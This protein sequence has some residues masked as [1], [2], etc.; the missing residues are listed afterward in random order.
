M[1]LALTRSALRANYEKLRDDFLN[2]D[3]LIDSMAS[4]AEGD[5]NKAIFKELSLYNANLGRVNFKGQHFEVTI[6]VE[7][8]KSH[9][10]IC[11][12]AL[13]SGELGS[14]LGDLVVAVDHILVDPYDQTKK[15]T[16][17]TCSIIQTK[18]E[19]FA[20]KGLSARQ[21]YLMTQWPK[22]KYKGQYWEFEVF[23]DIFSFY[24][25]VLDPS[26]EQRHKSSLLSSTI[27]AR[28]LGVDKTSLLKRIKGKIPLSNPN[29]LKREKIDNSMMPFSF[30]SF[31]IKSSYLSLGSQ[32]LGVR[33]FLK[34]IFFPSMEEVEDC[35][36]AI[37][38]R[39][40][41][42][43]MRDRDDWFRKYAFLNRKDEDILAIRLKV[44]LRR[45]E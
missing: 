23:P 12:M 5:I 6:E 7:G 9:G 36:L 33:E 31:L 25:F 32:S 8:A 35:N 22:F 15:I 4:A 29:V 38:R 27:L 20:K 45:L 44:I 42:S 11:D 40:I 17:G 34:Q 26:S 13:P 10:R 21:L 14:E 30:T 39:R 43:K 24:L 2:I 18:K 37:Q 28:F 41:R 19:K 1:F 3:R 16:N